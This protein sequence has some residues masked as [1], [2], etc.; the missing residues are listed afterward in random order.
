M[1]AGEYDKN[2]DICSVYELNEPTHVLVNENTSLYIVGNYVFPSHLIW[3]AAIHFTK[4]LLMT[5]DVPW[6]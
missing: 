3:I 4:I 5:S 2:S 1:F 6:D